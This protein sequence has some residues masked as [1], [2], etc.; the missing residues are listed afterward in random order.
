MKGECFEGDSDLLR[1]FFWMISTS[2]HDICGG[3]TSAREVPQRQ[4]AAGPAAVHAAV[5]EAPHLLGGLGC[6]VQP[7]EGGVYHRHQ[8]APGLLFSFFLL[9]V[10]VCQ[11][12]KQYA[13][14]AFYPWAAV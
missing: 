2:L 3:E 4:D 1:G 8:P 5:V 14:V 6:Q 12:G 10:C 9:C 13:K 11:S 7:R